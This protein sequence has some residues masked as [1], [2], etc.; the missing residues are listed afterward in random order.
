MVAKSSND[1]IILNDDKCVTPT[2]SA[3][4]TVRVPN[5]KSMGIYLADWHREAATFWADFA[6]EWLS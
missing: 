2:F 4:V 6:C 3:K 5:N 1:V